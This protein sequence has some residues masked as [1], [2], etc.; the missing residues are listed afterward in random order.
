MLV[1]AF[2]EGQD[3][4][5]ATA[6][7]VFGVELKDVTSDMRRVAKTVNF[8]IMYGMQAFGLSRDTGMSRQD[9]QDFIN[10]YMARLPGVR[11][12][13]DRTKQEA[14]SK[15]YVESMF[16]RR[17]YVPEITSSNFNVRL[18]AERIA[19]NMPLQGSAADIMKMA[20]IQVHHALKEQGFR[21]R[22]LLQVHDELLFEL[23][24][25]EIEPLGE[26]AATIMEQVVELR[27]P[28]GVERSVGLNWDQLEPV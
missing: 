3:I 17:R 23:P 10:R 1:T 25:S 16:G 22:I 28:L 7:D 4:H 26:L 9:A 5:A 13:L 8:G 18:G 27:V 2:R 20:M 19:I 14:A 12:F 6:A 11:E 24:R 21:G 15:G